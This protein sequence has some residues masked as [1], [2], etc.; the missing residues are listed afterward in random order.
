M[1]VKILPDKI[2]ENESDVSPIA[3][4]LLNE[5]LETATTADPP[6]LLWRRR[7]VDEVN[8]W[9]SLTAVMD[10]NIYLV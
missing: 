8:C 9:E 7:D 3:Y 1:N 2:W 4:S 10:M 5:V 6:V